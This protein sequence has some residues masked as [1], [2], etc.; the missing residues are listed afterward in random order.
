ML[1]STTA[2]QT[3]PRHGA[4]E[5]HYEFELSVVFDYPQLSQVVQ[6]SIVGSTG[7]LVGATFVDF[8]SFVSRS[9]TDIR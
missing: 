4:H 1:S 9:C 5:V 3:Q 6:V 2:S 8:E 7:H